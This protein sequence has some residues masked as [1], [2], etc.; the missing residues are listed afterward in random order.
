MVN[1]NLT[2]FHGLLVKFMWSGTISIG[3]PY[4]VYGMN[5]RWYI[6][7]FSGIVIVHLTLT[8]FS[9]MIDTCNVKLI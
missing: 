7:H 9:W 4:L 1:M 5:L 2:H 3:P 8:S 6:V